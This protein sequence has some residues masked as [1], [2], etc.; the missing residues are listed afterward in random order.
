MNLIEPS[1]IIELKARVKA[2]CARRK[3]VG[4]V[5]EYSEAG[6]DF[7]E[8]PIVD[9]KVL[10]EHYRQLAVPMNAINSNN[11]PD[12]IGIDREITEEDFAKME[13]YI[14]QYESRDIYDTSPTDCSSSCTGTCTVDCTG[15][16]GSG[17][18]GTCRGSCSGRCRGGCRGC[19]GTCKGSCT[20][21]CIDCGGQCA[22][23]CSGSCGSQCSYGCKTNCDTSCYGGCDRGCGGVCSNCQG[24]CTV[25]TG[26]GRAPSFV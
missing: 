12:V 15:G 23:S 8:T 10:E 3:Y 4:S 17:C 7:I 26:A 6:Y 9:Q 14:T 25:C 20:G 5:A 19:S 21:S 13:N 18:S 16:C 24:S 22:T 1:R 11:T 2:E